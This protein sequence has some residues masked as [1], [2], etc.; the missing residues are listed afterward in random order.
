MIGRLVG[1]AL[2]L[3][4]LSACAD[5][6]NG[7]EPSLVQQW[8]SALAGFGEVS[9]DEVSGGRWMLSVQVRLRNDGTKPIQGLRFG[10]CSFSIVVYEGEVPT[11]SPIWDE[12]PYYCRD[13]LYDVNLAP[14]SAMEEAVELTGGF[15]DAIMG[16]RPAGTYFVSTV[17]EPGAPY[18]WSRE[19]DIGRVE[20]PGP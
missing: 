11:G 18:G 20:L 6:T 14:G 4:A 15:V 10:E 13:I 12:K 16:G 3:V 19:F 9:L 2:V 1:G 5:S 8:D 7:P 17:L